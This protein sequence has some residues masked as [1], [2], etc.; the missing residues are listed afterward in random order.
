M[1]K[2]SAEELKNVNGGSPLNWYIGVRD[3]VNNHLD[4]FVKGVKAGW[5][6]K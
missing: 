6:S 5:N 4:D 2:L 1:K 3:F